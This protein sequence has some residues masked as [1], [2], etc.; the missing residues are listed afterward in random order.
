MAADGIG[1][2]YGEEQAEIQ[3]SVDRHQIVHN[4]DGSTVN[5]IGNFPVYIENC[6]D[7]KIQ[8][9]GGANLFMGLQHRRMEFPIPGGFC[10]DE[11]KIGNQLFLLVYSHDDTWKKVNHIEDLV[12]CDQPLNQWLSDRDLELHDVFGDESPGDLLEAELF[13]ANPEIEMLEGY[14]NLKSVNDI[15]TQKFRSSRRLNLRKNR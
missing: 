4:S 13:P 2:F 3:P 15:W 10:I 12:F 6:I 14:W 11:R 1:P 9:T 8:S 7:T 5:N